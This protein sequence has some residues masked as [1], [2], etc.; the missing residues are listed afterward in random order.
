MR[1]WLWGTMLNNVKAYYSDYTIIHAFLSVILVFAVCSVIELLRVKF[2]EKPFFVLWDKYYDK[3]CFK[4]KTKLNK[5]E[6]KEEVTV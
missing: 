4:F 6:N 3:L 2:I 1:F 5:T